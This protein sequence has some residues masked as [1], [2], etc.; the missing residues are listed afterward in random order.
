MSIYAEE[1]YEKYYAKISAAGKS[2]SLGQNLRH[3]P[4]ER[5]ISKV[6][7]FE[8]VLEVEGGTLST[9]L[10]C[11]PG[12]LYRLGRRMTTGRSAKKHGVAKL[13]RT[14]HA[15]EHRNRFA[16]LYQMTVTIFSDSNIQVYRSPTGINS[17][18]LNLFYSLTI[19]KPFVKGS[20]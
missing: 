15:F 7:K 1:W 4:L 20:K 10:P 14:V 17:W 6:V 12:I 16:S 3:V 11:G 18:N 9:L 13:G 8:R 19:R 5:G 2:N